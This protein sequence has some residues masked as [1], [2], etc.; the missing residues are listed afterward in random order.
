[1]VDSLGEAFE[2]LFLDLLVSTKIGHFSTSLTCLPDFVRSKCGDRSGHLTRC[3][4]ATCEPCDM[5]GKV[6]MG[7]VPERKWFT[8]SCLLPRVSGF[9]CGRPRPW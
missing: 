9:P 6:V 8:G 2:D 1:M 4:R 7:T 5:H 3:Y